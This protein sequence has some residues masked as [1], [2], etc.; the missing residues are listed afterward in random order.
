MAKQRIVWTKLW[1]DPWVRKLDS[2]GKLL[3]V[4]LLTNDKTNMAGVYEIS[5][6]DMLLETKIKR[7]KIL[8]LLR[9]F[10]IGEGWIEGQKTRTFNGSLRKNNE[11]ARTFNEHARIQYRNGWMLIGNF[12][13]YQNLN[14]KVLLGIRKSL[15]RVPEWAR[16][17]VIDRL[18]H[19]NLNLNLNSNTP[20][21]SPPSRGSNKDDP[22]IKKPPPRRGRPKKPKVEEP[23]L[24]GT[25]IDVEKCSNAIG[26]YK[27][28]FPRQIVTEQQVKQ[29]QA[30]VDWKRPEHKAAWGL[31]VERYFLN[32]DEEK[33]T[34]DPSKIG[35]VLSLFRNELAK[36]EAKNGTRTKTETDATNRDRKSGV[37]EGSTARR[38]RAKTL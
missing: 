9:K 23:R 5:I 18:S 28:A 7:E 36:L 37:P 6:E 38:V 3:W 14:P 33:G 4:Y 35:N 19:L 30:T 17:Y 27:A 13:G 10:A 8:K 1:S 34:Y 29:I 11:T 15:E 21:Y 20:P 2:D 26:S 22:E 16:A 31:T 24:P 25:L 32:F 12:L